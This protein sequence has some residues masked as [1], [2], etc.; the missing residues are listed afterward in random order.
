MLDGIN[1][2]EFKEKFGMTIDEVY[3]PILSEMVEDKMLER[4]DKDSSYKKVVNLLG[5]MR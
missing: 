4:E 1:T 3:G 2:D 5:K